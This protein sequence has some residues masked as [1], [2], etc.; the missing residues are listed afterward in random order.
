MITASAIVSS[1]G[2]SQLGDHDVRWGAVVLMSFLVFAL[3]ASVLAVFPKFTTH[4]EPGDQLPTDFNPLFF[5]HYARVP[6]DRYLDEV[7]ALLRDDGAIYKAIAADLYDQGVYL[8]QAKY[9]Y[10]RA[11]YTL[12]IAGFAG[13]AIALIIT[14]IVD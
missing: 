9:R 1:V 10:L 3:L 6:K 8:V 12:F 13:G 14:A 2:A 5:G 7:A 4:P 11:S